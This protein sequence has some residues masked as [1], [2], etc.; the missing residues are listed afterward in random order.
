MSARLDFALAAIAIGLL[1]VALGCVIAIVSDG[2]ALRSLEDRCRPVCA[3]AGHGLD[4]ATRSGT[5]ICDRMTLAVT[6]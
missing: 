3:K 5:C 2:H 4:Y 1:L 6:P